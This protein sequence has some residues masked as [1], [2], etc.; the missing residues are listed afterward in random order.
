MT[1]V[2]QDKTRPNYYHVAVRATVQG[3]NGF[4]H[5]LVD[6]E[7]FDLIDALAGGDFYLGNVWK[8]LFR[9]GKKSKETRTEDLAKA[10]EYL[11]QAMERSGP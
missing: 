9:A 1:D 3:P 6:V 11:N 8:Y 10:A 2:P 7:C 4:T 5:E